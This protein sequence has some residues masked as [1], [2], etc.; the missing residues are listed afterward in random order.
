[1][2]RR[3]AVIGAILLA[4]LPATP[5]VIGALRHLDADLFSQIGGQALPRLTAWRESAE[6]FGE[7]HLL[8]LVWLPR[9]DALAPEAKNAST[10]RLRRFV[11]LWAEELTH[12][13]TL[14]ED[15]EGLEPHDAPSGSWLTDVSY[16]L[17]PD[18]NR[19]FAE[20][21]EKHPQAVFDEDDVA[22]LAGRFQT[23]ALE[24]RL[25]AVR[26]A[27]EETDPLFS[28]ERERLRTDPLELGETARRMSER[29]R[30]K[31]ANFEVA[32]DAWFVS[33]DGSTAVVASRPTGSAQRLPFARAC[34]AAAGRAAQRAVARLRQ[35]PED[36][37]TSVVGH[38]PYFPE[39]S[40]TGVPPTLCLGFTGA[41][42]IAVE[43]ERGLRRDLPL[44][45]L[46]SLIGVL[47]VFGLAF[48]RFTAVV[49]LGACL[50]LANFFTLAFAGWFRGGLGLIAASFPCILF[51]MGVDYGMHY[52]TVLR[53]ARR[54]CADEATA[55][56]LAVSRVGGDV[57]A[58]AL[59][60]AAAFFG[61]ACVRFAGLSELGLLCGIGILISSFLTLTLLPALLAGNASAANASVADAFPK[62][63]GPDEAPGF[64]RSS[65]NEPMAANAAYARPRFGAARLAAGAI[66]IVVCG[67]AIGRAPEGE[68]A[69]LVRFDAEFGNLRSLR[70]TATPLRNMLKEKFGVEPAPLR[71]TIS[72][73]AEADVLSATE[74]AR[75]R[76]RPFVQ[77]GEIRLLGDPS[78]FAPS[79][80]RQRRN[81]RRLKAED[82]TAAGVAFDEAAAKAFGPNAGRFFEP[83]RERW[84]RFCRSVE[85]AE[86]T[87]PL[88]LA[89][90]AESPL[91]A[92]AAMFVRTT[93]RKT[94]ATIFGEAGDPHYS[95]KQARR[96]L[97]AL[98]TEPYECASVSV[99]LAGSRLIGFELKAALFEDM[100]WVSL[101]A[102][103]P[104]L[105]LLALAF[106]SV[107]ALF[108]ALTPTAFGL[109]ALL[110]G[111]ATAQLLGLDFSLNYVNLMIFPVLLGSS[112]D[113]GIYVT[114]A[115][116]RGTRAIAEARRT[117]WLCCLTTLIGYGSMIGGG[118]TG[119]ISFGW[120][121]VLAYLGALFGALAVLPVL[122]FVF[123]RRRIGTAV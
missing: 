30:P 102:L 8:G 18:V 82:W 26:I 112:V 122:A 61:L 95:E 23:A 33:P 58:A 86:E 60:T 37:E 39:L 11:K 54:E 55:A 38:G 2:R 59:S 49:R 78:L 12:V 3:R 97:E 21:L 105:L 19:I 123:Y 114:A 24:K 52:C 83:F 90:F 43:N 28:A 71:L 20:I 42:P 87:Q 79:P 92:L 118:F 70:I 69:A 44:T 99:R 13:G 5:G 80:E 22:E 74:T 41:L 101:I 110:G 109:T 75:E 16:R 17:D 77:A 32:Q 88:T 53:N 7:D 120:C 104:V 47:C 63:T 117:V 29:R 85:A 100:R 113:Y 6:L 103:T 96:W 81:L 111:V 76:L 35:N 25:H 4:L 64:E 84:A 93:E 27:Y 119:L 107:G 62:T 108:L 94:V 121:A 51:G 1:V 72:G 48:R 40:P 15:G 66:F 31:T 34:M 67:W 116:T 50:L 68:K 91:A 73:T 14:A 115:A 46:T 9:Q 106:R 98:E 56:G 65:R 10:A 57:I 45:A 36:A 89:H